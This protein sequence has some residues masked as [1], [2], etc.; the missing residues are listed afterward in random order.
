MSLTQW[1]LTFHG[2]EARH[3]E[4]GG[5]EG[6]ALSDSWGRTILASSG[7]CRFLAILGVPQFVDVSLPSHGHLLF[8]LSGHLPSVT[9]HVSFF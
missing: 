6:R 9:V 8:V 7:F 1:K 4:S 2:S 3:P 5:Q